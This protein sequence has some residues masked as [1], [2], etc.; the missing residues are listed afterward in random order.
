[1]LVLIDEDHL[2]V[3]DH[4]CRVARNGLASVEVVEVED[5]STDLFGQLSQ[6]R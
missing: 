4:R 5:A 3:V 2:V 1:M 6:Q